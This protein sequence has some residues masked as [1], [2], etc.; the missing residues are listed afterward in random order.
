MTEYKRVTREQLNKL[1]YELADGAPPIT[2][3]DQPAHLHT[4]PSEVPEIA[5]EQDILGKFTKVL[6]DRG[7]VG[8]D[9]TA[10]LMY[11]CLTSRLF[12]EPVSTVVKGQSS[13]GKS[14]TID[15]VLAFF[16][17]EAYLEF[18]A[19]SEHALVYDKRDFAHRTIVLFEAVALREQR[20]K[21]ES[22]LTAY[23]VRSL[24]SEGRIRYPVTQRN[25]DGEFVTKVIEKNGPTN[26]ILSTTSVSLHNENETRMLALPTND[27]DEQTGN[28]RAMTA[29][30]R[31]SRQVA[32]PDV[33]EWV[34]FQGW[35]ASADH[36][37]V[38]PFAEELAREIPPIAV[39][40]RRDFNTLLG[41]IEAHAMLHQLS[42]ERDEH[43]RIVA[44][45]ADY[46]AVRG[47]IVDLMSDGIDAAV[48][49]T[50]KE[51]VEAVAALAPSSREGVR[52]LQVA[53]K[54]GF[55]REA[56]TRRLL[57]AKHRGYVENEEDRRGREAR[58]VIGNPL[59]A[60][61]VLLPTSL[62]QVA[63]SE[64][65]TA[66]EGGVCSSAASAKGYGTPPP[67]GAERCPECAKS[68]EPR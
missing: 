1:G 68:T 37:V 47:L 38:V 23:F 60:D 17:E 34:R 21:S 5:R 35:L 11:L 41:L 51:A 27:A 19:M 62:A 2:P 65:E 56:T 48:A 6:H 39:R 12:P 18:T 55:S 42:R 20:E 66:G 40:L 14:Y 52:I 33:S 22:N 61:I 15:Q 28:V 9:R 32:R 59:P 24:L 26:M 64:D 30:K 25:K 16:P 31:Y 67:D 13:V 45:E 58:Y 3:S 53:A 4:L 7:L 10:Q 63:P 57:N 8:E 50:T 46:L 29:R 49:A 44:T 36:E 43:G 54:L